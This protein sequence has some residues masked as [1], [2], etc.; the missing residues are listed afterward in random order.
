MPEEIND[1]PNSAEASYQLGYRQ[2]K[3][4]GYELHQ[5]VS[6]QLKE[7]PVQQYSMSVV[8]ALGFVSGAMFEWL[9]R[10]VFM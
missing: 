9:V 4:D 10:V 2:G 7:T 1:V 8:F 3:V 5:Y 6:S